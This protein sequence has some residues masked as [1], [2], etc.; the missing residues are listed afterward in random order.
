[1][2]STNTI[3]HPSQSFP[4][5]VDIIILNT[6]PTDRESI[7]SSI[8]TTD[9]RFFLISAKN[10]RDKYKILW[11]STGLSYPRRCKVDILTPGLLN[12]PQIPTNRLVRLDPYNNLPLLPFIP[13]LLLKV[14]GWSHH[15]SALDKL[16]HR[17][18]VPQD[19][20][21]VEELVGIAVQKGFRRKDEEAWMAKEFVEIATRYVTEYQLV[22]WH[23]RSVKGK[24]WARIMD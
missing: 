14:Q 8:T 21:D 19:V 20:R 16:H 13:L 9:S 5:D 2:Y 24:E 6:S 4:K 1:M 18:K 12:I 17:K 7:K 3:F 11:F 23:F 10:P 22:N 15:R